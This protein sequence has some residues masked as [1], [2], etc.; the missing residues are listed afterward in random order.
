[1]PYV[2]RPPRRL[3]LPAGEMS[4]A[5]LAKCRDPDMILAHGRAVQEALEQMAHAARDSV[6]R[7]VFLE[8]ADAYRRANKDAGDR[9][10]DVNG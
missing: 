1:M 3:A 5:A 4:A 9:W 2:T 7:N 8:M 6:I 10:R